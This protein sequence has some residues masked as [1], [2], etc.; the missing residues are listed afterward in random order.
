MKYFSYK[1]KIAIKKI[2][3]SHILF[4]YSFTP[5]RP[6][7]NQKIDFR[8]LDIFKE[9]GLV[10]SDRAIRVHIA[11]LMCR[12]IKAIHDAIR[13]NSTSNRIMVADK[14]RIRITTIIFSKMI[15]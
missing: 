9:T 3:K 10:A 14:D 11:V 1:K 15:L 13:S 2:C 6:L 7:I 4:K 5:Q 12:I 8:F